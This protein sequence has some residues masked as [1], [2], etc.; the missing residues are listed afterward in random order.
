M[1]EWLCNFDIKEGVNIKTYSTSNLRSPS[2]V[3]NFD[4]ATY[5]D[6]TFH[7]AYL[8]T[9]AIPSVLPSF[10][11]FFLYPLALLH[12]DFLCQANLHRDCNGHGQISAAATAPHPAP[13]GNVRRTVD[14]LDY[15]E[16]CHC[17]YYYGG[18]C[19]DVGS[20]GNK[21]VVHQRYSFL[22]KTPSAMSPSSDDALPTG[23]AQQAPNA[24][25]VGREF[26]RQYYTLLNQAPLHLHRFYSANSSF[27]HGSLDGGGGGVNSPEG[28]G[29][30]EQAVRGQ[31]EIHQRIMALGFRNCRAKIRQVDS[32]ATLGDGVVVQ[33]A[34]EL[35]NDDRPHRRFM[36]TFVLAPQSH[37]KY[38]VHN[39]IFRYQACIR[40]REINISRLQG[41]EVKLFLFSH[42]QDEVFGDSV[43]STD[44]ISSPP[45]VSV[46][47]ASRPKSNG[48]RHEMEKRE[49]NVKQ[50][51]QPPQHQQ[52]AG[53]APVQAPPPPAVAEASASVLA[54]AAETLQKQQA[55]AAAAAAAQAQYQMDQKKGPVAASEKSVEENGS[56]ALAEQAARKP[57]PG[58]VKAHQPLHKDSSGE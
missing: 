14:Y 13:A 17:N 44:G 19:Y 6:D 47:P 20:P 30:L 35:S 11:L 43:S 26:V 25:A 3:W 48:E 34:G 41:I 42:P 22:F 2:E 53:M 7:A 54:Q 10:R 38:Y 56:G 28:G 15:A 31:Q 52:Q 46:D 33:V 5:T 27:V 1:H 4:A 9:T 55:A 18:T 23:G 37:K 12:F 49:E 29:E 32:H 51:P 50:A 36:Q 45:T 40:S 8:D 21:L 24:A 16:I 39:D 57:M 58:H